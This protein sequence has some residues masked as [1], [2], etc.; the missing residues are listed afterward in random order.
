MNMKQMCLK[1]LEAQGHFD[2]NFHSEDY[3]K[4]IVLVFSFQICILR[5]GPGLYLIL[6]DRHLVEGKQILF[7]LYRKTGGCRKEFWGFGD[8]K[9]F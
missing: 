8:F 2:A 7:K 6:I 3:E 5:L 9:D 1:H 4:I